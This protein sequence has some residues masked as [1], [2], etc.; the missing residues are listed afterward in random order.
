MS[1]EL[2]YEKVKGFQKTVDGK[3]QTLSI[4]FI[5]YEN[6]G[7]VVRLK[8]TK[9]NRNKYDI[10]IG[11]FLIDMNSPKHMSRYLYHPVDIIP[12]GADSL[13]KRI[14]EVVD[15]NHKKNIKNPRSNKMRKSIDNSA[16]KYRAAIQSVINRM[17][18]GLPV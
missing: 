18:K 7:D 2:G 1:E 6:D 15:N 14:K 9:N 10:S 12:T 5:L 4:S 16:R 13:L 17:L 8:F 11:I 3:D